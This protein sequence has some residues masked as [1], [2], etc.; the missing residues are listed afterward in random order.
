MI[1]PSSRSQF[2]GVVVA[3]ANR[4]GGDEMGA[5]VDGSAEFNFTVVAGVPDAAGNVVSNQP[6]FFVFD[7]SGADGGVVGAGGN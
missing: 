4:R 3:S 6:A 1:V 5:A 7:V 2:S